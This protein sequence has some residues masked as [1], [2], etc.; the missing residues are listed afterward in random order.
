[1][2]QFVYVGNQ[3]I[4]KDPQH[5]GPRG[6]LANDEISKTRLTQVCLKA[7]GRNGCWLLLNRVI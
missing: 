7:S 2:M 3:G 6:P 4:I 5:G 1:M